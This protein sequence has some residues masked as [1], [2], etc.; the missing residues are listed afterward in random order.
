MKR[1]T[2]AHRFFKLGLLALTVL[3]GWKVGAPQAWAQPAVSSEVFYD[4]LAPAGDWLYVSPYGQVWQPRGVGPDFRPYASSGHWVYT[5]Y[6][7][8]FVSDYNWGWATFHYGRW[9]LDPGYGWVW[10]PGYDWAPAWVDWRYGGGYIGWAPLAPFG[11]RIVIEAYYPAWCFVPTRYFLERN[12]YHYAAPIDRVHRV[13]G[14]TAPNRN[15]VVYSGTHWYAGPPP[16]HVAQEAGRPVHAVSVTPPAPGIVRPVQVGAPAG[17]ASSGPSARPVPGSPGGT[18]SPSAHFNPGAGWGLSHGQAVGGTAVSPAPP[19]P[20][21]SGGAPVP[22]APQPGPG[23]GAP[24]GIR[25]RPG[26]GGHPQAPSPMP[27]APPPGRS[28]TPAPHGQFMNPEPPRTM[29]VSPAPPTYHSVPYPQQARMS[30]PAQ[31]APVRDQR[32]AMQQSM[33]H[34][35]PPIPRGAPVMNQAPVSHPGPVGRQEG[36]APVP[37]HGGGVAA[38]PWTSKFH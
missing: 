21:H 6:G 20:F 27:A 5:D 30:P 7:W 38:H 14:I 8:S 9:A 36:M 12:F 28:G 4:Q 31:A 16:G 15:E 18:A 26:W 25:M 22:P 37:S 35:S 29:P 33:R 1:E 34:E 13:F 24:G 10:V 32:P 17:V 19:Y 23:P 2:M 11:A 3:I